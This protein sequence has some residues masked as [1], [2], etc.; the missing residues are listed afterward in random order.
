MYEVG[1]IVYVTEYLDDNGIEGNN[2]LFVVIDKDNRVVTAEYFGFLVSSHTEKNNDVSNYKY[3]EPLSK[4]NVNGLDVDSHV[5]CDQR[6]RIEPSDISYRIG[7]VDVDDY[8]RFMD[9]YDRY[10]E[11]TGAK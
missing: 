8:I 10:L 1:D 7:H 2:H 3:N 6:Y 5:K 4:S 11:E 9:S